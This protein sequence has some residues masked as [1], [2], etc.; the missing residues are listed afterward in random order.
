NNNDSG[1]GSL[2]QVL[3]DVP[4]GGGVQFDPGVTGTITLTT[5]QL[6]INKSV[7]IF[8]PGA[9]TL[10]VSGNN[11]SRVFSLASAS[12]IVVNISGLTITGGK[13]TSGAGMQINSGKVA[14]TDLAI[15]SNTA[16]S[17]SLGG[18]I[19]NE[20]GA[21]TILRC[22]IANNTVAGASA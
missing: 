17:A 10:A 11:A 7:S 13:A 2:R 16:N 3:T 14:L 19:D 21:V 12:P 6:L 8:G 4:D 15:V 9:R 18:G 1:A 20:G 22:T 5:G